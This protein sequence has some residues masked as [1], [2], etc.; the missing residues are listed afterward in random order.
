[1]AEGDVFA[2]AANWRI[3]IPALARAFAINIDGSL[4]TDG[5]LFSII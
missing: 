4:N 3:D 5:S 2:L 1:M